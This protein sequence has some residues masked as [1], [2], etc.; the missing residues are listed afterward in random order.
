VVGEIKRG[1]EEEPSDRMAVLLH[2]GGYAVIH[3]IETAEYLNFSPG[4]RKASDCRMN[5]QV[6]A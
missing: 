1:E 6:C 2:P 4:M 5:E 3:H